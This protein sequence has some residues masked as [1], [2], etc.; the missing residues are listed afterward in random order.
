MTHWI[1]RDYTLKSADAAALLQSDNS[2]AG[3]I[4]VADSTLMPFSVSTHGGAR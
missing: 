2:D 1:N 4:A 3:G